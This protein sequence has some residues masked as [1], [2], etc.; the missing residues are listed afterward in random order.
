MAS[1]PRCESPAVFSVF[2]R[3]HVSSYLQIVGSKII[4]NR[5]FRASH[6]CANTAQDSKQGVTSAHRY[7][8]VPYGRSSLHKSLKCDGA[9][10]VPSF[11]CLSADKFGMSLE[12]LSC[13][14]LGCRP[15]CSSRHLG[16]TW[17]R[18][19]V[20]RKAGTTVD[21]VARLSS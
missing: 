6:C 12:C 16:N 20:Y 19:L 9:P 18:G 17:L 5:I 4:E 2:A 21:S 11:T 8:T 15:T 13:T 3:L 10:N 14:A 7:G 1:I